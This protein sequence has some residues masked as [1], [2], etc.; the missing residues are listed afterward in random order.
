MA[1]KASD[2]KAVDAFTDGVPNLE[3][4]PRSAYNIKDGVLRYSL[5][6]LAV[7]DGLKIVWVG[8]GGTRY[9]DDT[10]RYLKKTVPKNR[11]VGHGMQP[12]FFKRKPPT[13]A[14]LSAQE[15]AKLRNSDVWKK[16]FRYFNVSEG[17]S[18]AESQEMADES[19][20]EYWEQKRRQRETGIARNAS[21]SEEDVA[22]EEVLRGMVLGFWL[23]GWA[24]AMDE[25]GLPLPHNI[26]ED[27]SPEPP[28][29]LTDFGMKFGQDLSDVNG[30][31][32]LWELA[33]DVGVGHHE[34][35]DFGYY[36]AMESLGHGVAWSDSHDDHGLKV[37]STEV[38]FELEDP[39]DEDS[40]I[41][42]WAESSKRLA[43]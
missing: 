24:D 29:A 7:Q 6:D 19:T 36:L 28:E 35:E 23:Q 8:H 3:E 32:P 16:K 39:E 4:G 40:A 10:Y 22:N 13:E 41:L 26:N 34:L 30:G 20:R 14:E 11:F 31:R 15:L 37:P 5:T 43:R 38:H 9:Q 1:L 12:N 25:A 17:Y 42:T 21:E 33:D 2:K 18:K 27:S